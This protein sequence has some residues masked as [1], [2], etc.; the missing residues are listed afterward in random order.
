[1]N[2]TSGPLWQKLSV[3]ICYSSGNNSLRPFSCSY[4]VLRF[5]LCFPFT[6]KNSDSHNQRFVLDSMQ[7][8][9]DEF[10]LLQL[11]SQD[12]YFSLFAMLSVLQDVLLV[13]TSL[14][15]FDV[16]SCT[17]PPVSKRTVTLLMQHVSAADCC[18]FFAAWAIPYSGFLHLHFSNVV[19]HTALDLHSFI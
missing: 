2:S 1:M 8:Q 11:C 9:S 4:K 19:A 18:L 6:L 14:F 12:R 13:P 17:S 5:Q 10:D 3:C 7:H 16:L 15:R